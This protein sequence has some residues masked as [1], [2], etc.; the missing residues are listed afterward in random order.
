MTIN[1]ITSTQAPA[2][3]A[4]P[5]PALTNAVKQMAGVLWYN[6]LSEMNK[7]GFG[8]NALGAGQDQFQSLFLWHIAQHDFGG[9]DGSLAAAAAAQLGGTVHS[10]PAAAKPALAP[11]PLT[12]IAS[13]AAAPAASSPPASAHAGSLLAQATQFAQS[14]WPQIT[15]AAQSLGVPPVAVLAQTALETGWGAAAPGNNLFGI[16]AAHGQPS[17][18]TQTHEVVNGVLTAQT[19]SFRA[20]PSAAASVSD[21]AGLIQTAYSAAI[22]QNSVLGYAQ[23]LQRGGYATDPNYATKLNSIAQSPLMAHVLQA[24]GASSPS[25]SGAS[26]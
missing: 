17:T 1:L 24:V 26:P 16:K 14:I 18:T 6:M 23:A 3:T 22:G 10:A 8:A 15:A 19:A 12:T 13:V 20:Y 5:S 2:Q 7:S 25:S 21:Y 9:L 4:T 11:A